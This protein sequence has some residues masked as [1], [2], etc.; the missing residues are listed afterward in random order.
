MGRGV[1]PVDDDW[2]RWD[3]AALPSSL[4]T[5]PLL[6]KHSGTLRAELV[7]ARGGVAMTSAAPFTDKGA[8]VGGKKGEE[9]E[10]GPPKRK[11]GT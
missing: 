2:G 1:D 8:R 4:A 5:A 11:I 3:P 6:A 9:G 10:K 7:A